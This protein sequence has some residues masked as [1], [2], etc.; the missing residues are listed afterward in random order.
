MK[1]LRL[2]FCLACGTYRIAEGTVVKTLRATEAPLGNL[3]RR[4]PSFAT[5]SSLL[6]TLFSMKN[7]GKHVR[8]QKQN[9]K[10]AFAIFVTDVASLEWEDAL[11]ILAHGVKKAAAKSRHNITLLALSPERFSAKKEEQLKSFGFQRVVKKPVPVAA[12]LVQGKEAREHMQRV[13]GGDSRFQFAMA[14]ETVKYWGMALTEYDRVL[15]LD[16]DTMILD[17]MDELMEADADF[18]GTYDH[19]LDT[20]GSTLPPAQ[21]GFLLFRPSEADFLEIK[22][23]TQEGDWGGAGWKGS[24]IGWCYGGVGPDGL[25]A[26]YYNKDALTYLKSQSGKVSLAE[27]ISS[28]QLPGSRMLAVDRSIYDVVINDRLMNEMKDANKEQAVDAVKS[29]HFTGNCVKP[30][31]CFEPRDFLCE[32]LFQKWWELRAEVEKEAGLEP[33]KKSCEN[34]QYHPLKRPKK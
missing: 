27:G 8:K 25:L 32:G 2:L 16:A 3:E 7:Y 17:P 10:V 28:S 18:V 34:G 22:R 5:A 6:Q 13:N 21:G 26:Y 11:R 4:E 1:M 15:V 19:G 29:A 12:E 33:T 31:T 23:L 20:H 30:W 24:G 9:L 14:E